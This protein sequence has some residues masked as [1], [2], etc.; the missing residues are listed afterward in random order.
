MRRHC[1]ARRGFTLIEMLVAFAVG[2]LVLV[3]LA[4]IISSSLTVSRRTN[5]SLM[6]ASG[7]SAAIDMVANDLESVVATAQ[8]FAVLETVNDTVGGLSNVKRVFMLTAGG[9]DLLSANASEFGQVRAISYRL[10]RQDII[11]P[12]G[13]N[14]VYGLYRQTVS[15]NQTFSGFL[16]RTDNLSGAAWPGSASLDELILANVVDFQ[17]RLLP[18]GNAEPMNRSNE[19]IL[20]RGRTPAVSGANQ[21][22]TPAW[23]EVTLVVLQDRENIIQRVMKDPTLLQK[24][25]EQH[26]L[27]LT[28]RVAVRNAL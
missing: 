25:I 7:A 12:G 14:D 18:A 17:V 8:P 19:P 11:K 1:H 21:T 3:T 5:S 27:R 13:S 4:Q 10:A 16:G 23:I 24:A 26:G 15:S 22:S 20:I 2:A 9:A 6:A 28:R